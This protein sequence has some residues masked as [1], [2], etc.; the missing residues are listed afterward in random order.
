M[1]NNPRVRTLTDSQ[2]VKRSE[3][4]LISARQDFF[5]IF[6]SLRKEISSKNSVLVV[7]DILRLFVDILR[8]DDKYSLSIKSSA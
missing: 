3:N 5:Q 4:L 7:P 6:W 1:P 8:P 2:H